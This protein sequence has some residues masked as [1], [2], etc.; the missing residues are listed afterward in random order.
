MTST[1][2]DIAPGPAPAP[3]PDRLGLSGHMRATLVLALPLAGSH[4]AQIAISLTDTLMLGWY[5]VPELAAGTLAHALFMVVFLMGSGFAMAVMP[6]AA[7]AEAGGSVTGVRRVV[8]MGIWISVLIASVGLVPMWVSGA[9]FRAMG[10]EGEVAALAQEYLRIAMWGL[11]P[12]LLVM[13]L[14]SYLAALQRPQMVLWAT[15]FAAVLNAALNWAF[16]FGNWGA[17]ELGLRGAALAS[18]GTQSFALLLL[19]AYSGLAPRFRAYTL[20]ARFWRPDWA[21]FSEVFRLGWPIGLTM[22]AEAGLF[23]ATSVLMGL[24]GTVELAA[25]GIAIQIV[26]VLFMVHLGIANAATVRTG[27]A[28]GRGDR[29][30]LRRGAQ[31]AGLLS[32]IFVAVSIALMLAF[33]GLLVT[34]FL[35]RADP[36]FPQIVAAGVLLLTVS[37]LFLAFDG[38]QVVVL[39]LLRGM[40]DTRAPMLIA[41][42]SYWGIGMPACYVLAFPLGLGG[43]GIWLG[44]ALGLAV[45]FVAMLWRFNRLSA[46]P[47][48]G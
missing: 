19:V 23:S 21:A 8:R 27:H 24:V 12:A 43:A 36:A 13:V 30:A 3:L 47:F 15:I 6:M 29:A 22:L 44:L 17:P 32:A 4:V 40:K 41:A 14:K 45:A 5:G 20:Y 7:A 34:L 16:I 35:D 26:A 46:R 37:T 2:P 48:H 25:H 31:A 39:G 28:L 1:A 9:M 10:I 42:F 38:G 18:V 11:F 33:P